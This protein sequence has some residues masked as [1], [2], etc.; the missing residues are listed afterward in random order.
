MTEQL[1]PLS[2]WTSADSSLAQRL[3]QAEEALRQREEQLAALIGQS[4]AG[5]GQVDLTGKFTFV[6]DRF[7]EITGRTRQE[8]LAL[9][10]QDI[11]HPDDLPRNISLFERARSDGAP[12]VHEK[13]YGRMARSCG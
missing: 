7:C 8:L 2:A 1:P 13:R 4:A 12:F 5:F 10:M 9:R 6:N 11:T 3:E